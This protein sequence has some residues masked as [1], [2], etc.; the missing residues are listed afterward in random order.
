MSLQALKHRDGDKHLQ[1]NPHSDVQPLG[2]SPGCPQALQTASLLG[3][4][5]TRLQKAGVLTSPLLS[6][7]LKCPFIIRFYCKY[8]QHFMGTLGIQCYKHIWTTWI[9]TVSLSPLEAVTALNLVQFLVALWTWG[10]GVHLGIRA[11]THHFQSETKVSIRR[12]FKCRL[13]ITRA[14]AFLFF[15]K[16]KFFVKKWSIS[17][18][19]IWPNKS[20]FKGDADKFNKLYA[21]F[22]NIQFVLNSLQLWKQAQN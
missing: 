22:S 17:L 6:G 9:C 8:K 21:S 7:A 12:D 1:G 13:R 10:F 4:S 16:I 11:Q 5:G 19:F 2:W 15:M 20:S 3:C 14:H 18:Q